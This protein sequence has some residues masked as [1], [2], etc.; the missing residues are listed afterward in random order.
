MDT[1][2]KSAIGTECFKA[3]TA[4]MTQ[5]TE[6]YITIA[7]ALCSIQPPYLTFNY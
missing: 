5:N 1:N 6:D 4:P 3:A 7:G 2:K